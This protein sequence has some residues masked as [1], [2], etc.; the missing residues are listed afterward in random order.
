MASL[1]KLNKGLDINLAG[2]AEQ[3]LVSVKAADKVTLVPDDFVGSTP[4]VVV[5]AGEAVK[6][7]D[8]L[9]TDKLHPEIKFVS[10]V[11]GT[12]EEVVRGERRKVL[13]VVVVNDGKGTSVELPA[14]NPT[15]ASADEIKSA[16]LNAG[17]WP[18]IKQRP[19]NV[20]ANPEVQPRDIFVTAMDTAPLAPD[21]TFVVK[22]QEEDLQRGISALAKLTAGKVYVGAKAGSKLQLKDAEVVEFAGPHPAGNVGV[23]INHIKPIN[24]GE[25]VWTVSAFDVI[26]MGR[27]LAGKV[28]FTRTITVAGSEVVSP[29]YAKVLPGQT[30]ASIL[31]G[32][33]KHVEYTQRYIAGN[34]LTGQN[35]GKDGVVGF[36][37]NTVTVIP[38]GGDTDELFGWITPGLNR[39]STSNTGLSGLFGLFKSKKW[40]LDAR[41]KGGPRALIVSGTWEKVFPMD[42]YPEELYKAVL[43]YNIDKMEALGIYEV[44]PEDFALCEFVDTSKTPVQQVIADG[45]VKLR[46]EME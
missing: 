36:F 27:A 35:A 18:F 13:G 42:I 40:T 26:V 22:G 9:F 16:L 37:D 31:D 6:A 41:L 14:V 4:K 34:V 23:Q 33:V 20:V 10:P 7:G 25:Q 8:V 21:F 43:T 29:A 38:D 44:A 15:S 12:V 19:Y 39:Y 17:V 2:A 28:D 46:K 32:N 5:K 1:I 11:S 24:K 45:L 3:K 30:L